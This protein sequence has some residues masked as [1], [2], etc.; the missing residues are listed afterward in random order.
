LSALDLPRDGLI[1]R[2]IEFPEEE[3]IPLGNGDDASPRRDSSAGRIAISRGSWT[4]PLNRPIA[5]LLR[6][7][8]RDRVARDFTPLVSSQMK[9]PSDLVALDSQEFP[10]GIP[11]ASHPSGYLRVPLAPAA[12]AALL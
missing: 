6:T 3:P 9:I 8:Q 4:L 12:V 5:F 11:N 7:I 1:E 2:S 10:R